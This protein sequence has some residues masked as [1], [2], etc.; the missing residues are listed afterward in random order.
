MSLL[1][2]LFFAFENVRHSNSVNFAAAAPATATYLPEFRDATFS[3]CAF[4]FR[5]DDHKHVAPLKSLSKRQLQSLL[6][7]PV[8]VN[9]FAWARPKTGGF[10]IKSDSRNLK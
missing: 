4:A 2:A 3:L 10:Q 6:E 5:G 7:S 1:L 9:A 8:A